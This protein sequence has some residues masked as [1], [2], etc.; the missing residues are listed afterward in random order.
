[1]SFKSKAALAAIVCAVILSVG[2]GDT[3]RPIATPVIQNGGQPQ[4]AREAVVLSSAGPGADGNT[5]HINV[6]GD[7]N[8][9]Q[10]NVGRDPVHLAL[11]FAGSTVIV[12]NR[13]EESLTEYLTFLPTSAQPATFISLPIG[14]VPVFSY[15]NVGGEVF[16]AESGRNK[17]GIV[18]LNGAV[19][20]LTS[21]IAVGNTPVGLVGTPDTTTLFVA[22]KGDGTVT[23]LATGTN[24]IVTTLHVGGSAGSAPSYLTINSTGTRV[25]SVNSGSNNVSVIDTSNNVVNVAVGTTPSFAYFDSINNRFWVTNAGSNSV[26]AINADVN[27]ASY[28]AVTTIPVTVPGC[29]NPFGSIGSVL[30]PSPITVLADGSRAYVADSGCGTVSVINT[31]SNSVTKTIPVGT[32][33]ISIVSSPDSSKVYVANN[34]SG[35]VS[36]IQTSNDTVVATLAVPAGSAPIGAAIPPN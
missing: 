10:V 30:N 36:V 29:A 35:N 33:P 15:S 22:N 27:S 11:I 21:E 3:F 12:T 6:S 9:G 34:G 7:T 16:V 19:P 17:V 25:L 2:C 24:S 18:S 13:S 23:V 31:L 26:S 8:V 14:S 5:L 20:G 32:T 1:M 28:L 4:T